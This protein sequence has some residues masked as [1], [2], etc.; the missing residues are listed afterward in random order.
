MLKN[1]IIFNIDFKRLNNTVKLNTR[2]KRKILK[3]IFL[4]T[5]ISYCI[6]IIMFM[7]YNYQL[8]NNICLQQKL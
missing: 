8:I 1:D 4:F 3:L 5:S 7:F 6:I 2:R